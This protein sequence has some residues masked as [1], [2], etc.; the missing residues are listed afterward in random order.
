MD[1]R[2]VTVNEDVSKDMGTDIGSR[3]FRWFGLSFLDRS[4]PFIM[5]ED[6]KPAA[7]APHVPR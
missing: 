2:V 4:Q 6:R 7:I 1:E 5:T 3:A